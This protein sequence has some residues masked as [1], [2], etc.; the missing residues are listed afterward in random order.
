ML[1][2]QVLS[3]LPAHVTEMK[4]CW[5]TLSVI[6]FPAGSAYFTGS[7]RTGCVWVGL[8][9]DSRRISSLR[10]KSWKIRHPPLFYHCECLKTC[11]KGHNFPN[12]CSYRQVSDIEL[13]WQFESWE[14]VSC[15]LRWRSPHLL[16]T[17][18]SHSARQVSQLYL[19]S[20]GQPCSSLP[21]HIFS[22]AERAFHQ[23]FQE[24]RP[25]CFILR[26]ARSS[27]SLQCCTDALGAWLWVSPPFLWFTFIDFL[28]T[29][30]SPVS[31]Q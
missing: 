2:W 5:D 3:T 7:H 18:V 20:T 27:P 10:T 31:F 13:P 24:Q 28:S 26:W 25:Q 23:L 8:L 11:W 17:S 16:M 30:W 15:V 9:K 21:P 14:W 6:S 12:F 22:C 4:Y 1:Q 19:S 29:W